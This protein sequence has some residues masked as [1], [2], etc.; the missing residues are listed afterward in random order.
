MDATAIPA[1]DATGNLPPGIYRATLDAIEARFCTGEVRVHWGQVLREVVALAQSTGHV[2]A[3]YIFGSFVT[4]K[5]AP[6]DLDLFVIMTADFVSERVE[7]RARL[8]FDRPRAALV[9]G[10]CLYWM[11]AQTDWTPFLAAWQL[12]RDGG[13]RGIVEIAW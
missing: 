10:I 7:G 3:I 12:R 11:T 6:A 5:V 9:W 8:V 2:E 13:T 1:F 4:A